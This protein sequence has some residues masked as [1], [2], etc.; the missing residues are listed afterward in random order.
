LFI[1]SFVDCLE[2][3][4]TRLER[5]LYNLEKVIELSPQGKCQDI[6]NEFATQTSQFIFCA[7][8]NAKPIRMCRECGSYFIDLTSNY[9]AFSNNS[10]SGHRCKDI[11]TSQDS[12]EIIEETY[13]YIAAV[14]SSR[15]TNGLF[16][17]LWNKGNCNSC[18]TQPFSHDSTL[19]K[20]TTEFFQRERQVRKCFNQYPD[21]KD[22]PRNSSSACEA[23]LADY[24]N[25]SSFYREHILGKSAPF[26]DNVC[27]DILD[28]MNMT[29][30]QWGE[31]FNCGRKLEHHIIL[32]VAVVIIG[33]LP[34]IFYPTVR[35][36]GTSAEERVISQRHIADFFDQNLRRLSFNR[37]RFSRSSRS[38]GE[39][40]H[41]SLSRHITDS[42]PS[43]NSSREASD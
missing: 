6:L 10:E 28:A 41:S 22:S 37:S 26:T 3:S 39:N 30:R 12:V 20:A 24:Q 1:F 11:L 43:S 32:L 19:N 21:E 9:Q 36:L 29:Q 33:S 25:L 38:G 5:S 23:C 7:N 2:L 8:K 15:G 4:T 35:V 14:Q 17:G 31:N 13:N 40:G 18:Y 27:F 42:T 34:L 16:K